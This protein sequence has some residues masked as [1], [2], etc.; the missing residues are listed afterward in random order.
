MQGTLG[1]TVAYND[2]ASTPESSGANPTGSAMKIECGRAR[3]LRTT[4]L[5]A[6]LDYR[7]CCPDCSGVVRCMRPVGMDRELSALPV[8]LNAC[9]KRMIWLSWTRRRL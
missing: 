8:N 1:R 3:A 4:A 2:E 5:V 9:S 7:W 6:D